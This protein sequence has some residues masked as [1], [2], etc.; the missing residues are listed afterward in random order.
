ML[1]YTQALKLVATDNLFTNLFS[2]DSNLV[3]K[4]VFDSD[5]LKQTTNINRQ[6]NVQ[7]REYIINGVQE[8]NL[9]DS[10]SKLDY[11]FTQNE[12]VDI[13]IKVDQ[14][15]Q[16]SN[17]NS[18]EEIALSIGLYVDTISNNLLPRAHASAVEDYYG[19]GYFFDITDPKYGVTVSVKYPDEYDKTFRVHYSKHSEF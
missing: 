7:D 11:T 6:F 5:T 3:Y 10:K 13:V 17:E 8:Y 12:R 4:K 2:D 19:Q 9:Y 16:D 18:D 1:D 14:E 15:Y